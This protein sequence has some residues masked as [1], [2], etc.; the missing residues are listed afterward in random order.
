MPKNK[1]PP[2]RKS[3]Q[4]PVDKDEA[5]AVSLSEMALDLAE[6]ELGG[7]DEEL[8]ETRSEQGIHAQREQFHKLVR[9][10]LNQKND[11]V[12]YDAIERAREADVDAYQYLR[13]QIEEA[14]ATLTIRREGAPVMEIDAFVVPLFV[15]SVGGL[16]SDD[17][18]QDQEAFDAL[19]ASIG[20]AGLESAAARVVLINHAYDMGEIDRITY[21]HLSEML[22]DAHASMTEKKIA[23]TPA[24]ER[25]IAGW[26]GSAFGADD[27]AVEL[28]FLLGFALKR[29]DD[30]FYQVPADEAAAD[31]YFEARMRR[32][33]AWTELA[34]PLLAR[35]LA[36]PDQGVLLNFLYQDLFH[37][38]KEQ[39]VAEYFMLQMMA[40][41][42]AALREHK[43]SPEQA[44]A[45]VAPDDVDGAM[46]LRVNLH[47]AEGGALLSSSD[48]PLDLAAD[49]QVE[50]DDVCDALATLGIAGVAVAMRFDAQGK[51]I[52]VRPYR[53]H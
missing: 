25:S 31:A 1:R 38:G 43:L 49:L 24:L 15:H 9:K 8:D 20:Q 44:T 18:F 28:R 32:F 37:G 29:A 10:L 39:G 40:D 51:A 45:L 47:A 12:L 13:E 41:I 6:F 50:V 21:A 3:H 14:S 22:R 52:D 33:Q 26:S 23:A 5:L 2:A 48:K 19:V 30:P 34:R 27:K 35:C 46:V 11:A 53:A 42:N 36:R 7:V 16:K 17:C 4:A